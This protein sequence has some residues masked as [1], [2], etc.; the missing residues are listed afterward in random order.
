MTNNRPEVD[1]CTNTQTNPKRPDK[2]FVTNDS[3]PMM[4]HNTDGRMLTQLVYSRP[5]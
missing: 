3:Q 2:T 5:L 1:S 4:T